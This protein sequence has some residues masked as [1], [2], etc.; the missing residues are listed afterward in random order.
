M[1]RFK[2]PFDSICIPLFWWSTSSFPPVDTTIQP[3]TNMGDMGALAVAKLGAKC[4]CSEST[5]GWRVAVA[6]WRYSLRKRNLD[7][8]TYQN[9]I[10]NPENWQL[11]VEFRGCTP[12]SFWKRQLVP[13]LIDLCF[14]LFPS[15][16][17]TTVVPGRVKPCH[18]QS[19]QCIK[20]WRCVYHPGA[21][22]AWTIRETCWG[23]GSHW[24]IGSNLATT[25]P[26]N[27]RD[28]I[29]E[30]TDPWVTVSQDS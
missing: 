1:L 13:L 15:I 22:E 27:N 5:M 12:S 11:H 6:T 9:S 10:W 8:W 19:T 4:Q 24:A 21:F 25:K 14:M 28:M 26:N 7:P 20:L 30:T 18:C 16:R 23:D 17:Q 3:A 29:M 2:I